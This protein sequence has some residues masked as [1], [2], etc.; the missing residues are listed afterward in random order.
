M[1][2]KIWKKSK[3]SSIFYIE[4]F[5]DSFFLEVTNKYSDSYLLC[6]QLTVITEKTRLTKNLDYFVYEDF[7]FKWWLLYLLIMQNKTS[8]N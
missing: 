8:K 5:D 7:L 3:I 6:I 1:H 4:I 2:F